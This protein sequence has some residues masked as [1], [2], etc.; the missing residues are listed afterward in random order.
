VALFLASQLIRTPEFREQLKS[1]TA[2]LDH[3]SKL[4]GHD[5][6]PSY[7]TITEEQCREI[8]A[9]SI[10]TMVPGLAE[11]MGSDE[12]DSAPQSDVDA[13]LEFRSSN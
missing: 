8:Q 4:H 9:D 2:Q 12:M 7:L 13:V 1:I 5:L 10:V 11:T 3:W 6:D